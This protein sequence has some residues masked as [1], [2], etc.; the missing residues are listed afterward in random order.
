VVKSECFESSYFQNMGNGKFERKSL[1]VE[2][3]FAPVFGMIAG[4]YNDDGNMDV[5]MAGNSYAT[6]ASTGRYDAMSGLLLAGDGKGNFKPV[7]SAATH[8]KADADVKSLAEI[9]SADGTELILVGNNSG[10]MESYRLNKSIDRQ[11]AIRNTDVYA[12]IHKENGQQYRQEFYFGSNYLSSSSRIL[13]AGR[14]VTS[15]IIYDVK[16][17]NR[18]QVFKKK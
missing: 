14:D 5:L 10:K 9:L 11:I 1:P 4:D 17:K 13:K 16:G 6:D 3:Q 7:N 15:V 2:A 18:E 12:I 8:F